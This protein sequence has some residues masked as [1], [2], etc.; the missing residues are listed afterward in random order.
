MIKKKNYDPSANN[1]GNARL[2]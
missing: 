1:H 2:I